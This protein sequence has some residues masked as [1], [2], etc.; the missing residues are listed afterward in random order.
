MMAS[1]RLASDPLFLCTTQANTTTRPSTHPDLVV[2]PHPVGEKHD[3]GV[4]RQP[5]GHIPE[6]GQG[7]VRLGQHLGVWGFCFDPTCV[8]WYVCVSI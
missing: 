2:R 1:I 3:N 6:G 4:F 7:I 8:H 5:G